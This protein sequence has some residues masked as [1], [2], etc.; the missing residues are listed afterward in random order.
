MIFGMVARC[1]S[2]ALLNALLVAACWHAAT[3]DAQGRREHTRPTHTRDDSAVATREA[4]ISLTLAPVAEQLLQ[5]WIRTAGV[6]E[7]LLKGCPSPRRVHE[8][9]DSGLVRRG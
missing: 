3:I 5:T 8:C 4:E 7:V 6:I 2:S 9:S 1:G